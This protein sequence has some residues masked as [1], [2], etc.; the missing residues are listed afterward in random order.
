MA[1]RTRRRKFNP[2]ECLLRIVSHLH[3]NSDAILEPSQ[4][5]PAVIE[6]HV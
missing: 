6:I 1:Q 2:N 5:I 4:Y 3:D